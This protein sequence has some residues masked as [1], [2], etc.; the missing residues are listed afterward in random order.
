[1]G[2]TTRGRR[3]RWESAI[4]W[5]VRAGLAAALMGIAR[6]ESMTAI[7]VSA[8]LLGGFF[9]AIACPWGTLSDAVSALGRVV[10]GRRR[11]RFLVPPRW[12][13]IW[14]FVR[15]A[16]LAEVVAVVAADPA[17]RWFAGPEKASEASPYLAWFLVAQWAALLGAALLVDRFFCLYLCFFRPLLALVSRASVLRLERRTIARCDSCARCERVCPMAVAVS[18]GATLQGGDCVTCLAC[19]EACPADPPAI[20]PRLFGRDIGRVRA[21]EFALGGSVVFLALSLVAASLGVDARIP[22]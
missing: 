8:V 10:L 17:L 7:I 1:M 4:V 9:C 14:G 2:R 21:V 3:S 22:F 5:S 15:W 16:I 11:R 12:H 18:E 6:F 19:V 13:R 20:A